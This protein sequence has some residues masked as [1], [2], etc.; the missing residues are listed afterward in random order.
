MKGLTIFRKSLP[1]PTFISRIGGRRDPNNFKR[2][3]RTS[4]SFVARM[5]AQRPSYSDEHHM[6]A[7][8]TALKRGNTG[9]CVE[10]GSV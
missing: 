2:Y 5:E 6:R 10:Y 9:T 1:V 8:S 3:N 7:W 4:K